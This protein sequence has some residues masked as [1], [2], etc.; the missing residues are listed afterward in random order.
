VF[1][2]PQKIL[3][4]GGTFLLENSLTFALNSIKGEE[5]VLSS[6][7]KSKFHKKTQASLKSMLQTLFPDEGILLNIFQFWLDLSSDV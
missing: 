3:Q 7:N 1:F 6:L 2:T 4:L 5:E